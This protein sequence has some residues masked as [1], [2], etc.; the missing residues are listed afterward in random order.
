MNIVILVTASN[1]GSMKI[2]LKSS[3]IVVGPIKQNKKVSRL[4]RF[5]G[6]FN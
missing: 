5:S 3:N 2:D 4:I 6:D 1:V